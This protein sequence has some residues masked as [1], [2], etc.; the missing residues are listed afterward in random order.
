MKRRDL[1]GGGVVFLFGAVTAVLSAQMPIGTFRA[2]GSGLFPLCL[3]IL[4]MALSGAY[5]VQVFW[6]EK[7]PNEDG[8]SAAKEEGLS[9][10]VIAF[11]TIMAVATLFL[12]TLGYA[13]VSFLLMA[14]L[15]R[16]LGL[17]RWPLNVA[18]SLV[19]A[20]ASHTL[21]VYVL[22]IPLPRGFLGI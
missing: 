7:R 1:I 8:T 12:H 19:T 2:A 13:V 6:S 5:M 21:F 14:G 10:P 9:L 4:L 3:G 18:L 17:K 16:V 22:K 15:L 20:A 11:L